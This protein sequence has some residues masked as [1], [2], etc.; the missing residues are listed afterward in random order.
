RLALRGDQCGAGRTWWAVTTHRG[1]LLLA[2]QYA[3]RRGLEGFTGSQDAYASDQRGAEQ[4]QQQQP[5]MRLPVQVE[6]LGVEQRADQLAAQCRKQAAES[7]E[8]G[9]FAA[10]GLQQQAPF[11]AQRAQQRRLPGALVEGSL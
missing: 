5:G 7:A 6:H 4:G 3:E 2:A 8:Q 9:E 11:R 10:P 1:S